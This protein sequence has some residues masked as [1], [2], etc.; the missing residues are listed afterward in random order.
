MHKINILCKTSNKKLDSA[1]KNGTGISC[2]IDS[3]YT[4]KTH[5]NDE[6]CPEAMKVNCLTFFNVGSHGDKGGE[7]A[8]SLYMKR[9]ENSEKFAKEFEYDFLEMDSNISDIIK[10]NYPM[11]HTYRNCAAVLAMQK[12][13]STYYY[14]SGYSIYDFKIEKESSAYYDTFIFSALSNENVTFYSTGVTKTRMEKTISVAEYAPSYK[15]L[16]ICTRQF[17]NCGICEKCIRTQLSLDAVGKL[18]EY[19][20]VFNVDNY[21]NNRNK[22][23]KKLLKEIHKGNIYYKEIYKYMKEHKIRIPIMI[24]ILSFIPNKEDVKHFGKKFLQKVSSE[25]QYEDI[26]KKVHQG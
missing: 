23:Y 5:A 2:G 21:Y 25:K 26:I 20:D 11:T 19:K 22:Y 12:Y 7:K 10:L 4:I 14:S 17:K 15:F 6:E 8:R 13:F 1:E 9:K 18:N 16:N 3:F 24:H